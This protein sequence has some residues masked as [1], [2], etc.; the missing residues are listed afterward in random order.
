MHERRK[1]ET[2]VYSIGFDVV[3]FD[4][5]CC[6]VSMGQVPSCLYWWKRRDTTWCGDRDSA[7]GQ[8]DDSV[9][10]FI[11]YMGERVCCNGITGCSELHCPWSDIQQHNRHHEHNEWLSYTNGQFNEQLEHGV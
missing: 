3:P 9:Q 6:P 8:S 1:Y 5:D 2:Q 4:V 10:L 11:W 7:I